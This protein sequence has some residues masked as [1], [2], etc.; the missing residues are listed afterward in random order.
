MIWPF[1]IILLENQLE[2]H[3]VG[4]ET[5]AK[6][7]KKGRTGLRLNPTI[8]EIIHMIMIKYRCDQNLQKYLA[9]QANAV[10][11]LNLHGSAG[12]EGAPGGIGGVCKVGVIASSPVFTIL[13]FNKLFVPTTSV[14]CPHPNPLP[15]YVREPDK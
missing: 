5:E 3:L 14:P 8:P 4:E 7:S 10:L 11:V 9:A 6:L 13:F 1:K 12:E 15:E 2:A